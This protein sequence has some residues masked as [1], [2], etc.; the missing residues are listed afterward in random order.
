[1]RTYKP[2]ISSFGDAAAN[3]VAV[4]CYIFI[5]LFWTFGFVVVLLIFLVEKKSM[6]VRF[7]A[8]QAIFLWLARSVFGGGLTYESIAAI[9]TGNSQYMAIPYGWSSPAPVLLARLA[10]DGIIILCAII[11]LT[12]AYHWRDWKIPFIGQLAM[13]ICRKCTLPA[14]CGGD[15]LPQ[16]CWTD[17]MSNREEDGYVNPLVEKI[18]RQTNGI[19]AVDNQD[20]LSDK[21]YPTSA[22]G[23]QG[24]SYSEAP[25]A[26]RLVPEAGRASTNEQLPPDMRD[27]PRYDEEAGAIKAADAFGRYRGQNAGPGDATLSV[28]AEAP[29]VSVSEDNSFGVANR[30]FGWLKRANTPFDD[31][32]ALNDPNRSL[33]PEMRDPPQ[34]DMF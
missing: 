13:L 26:A 19:G 21:I 14:Y 5:L 23:G 22:E 1:M 4:A 27:L 34:P 33:P 28:V 24:L 18:Y 32:L 29:L 9:I 12:K 8:M 6:L 11:A 20:N 2:H 16:Q 30:L 15:D 25:K 3:L 7:H 17:A 10:V 31:V